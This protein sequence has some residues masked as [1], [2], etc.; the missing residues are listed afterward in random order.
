MN[1]LTVVLLLPLFGFLVAMAL[2][3][4]SPESSRVWA[5]AGSL[6]TFAASL[7]LLF[8][9]DRGGSGEQFTV[10]VP[11]ITTPDIHFSVAVN[12]VSLWLILLST[13]LTP[14]C[15]LISWNSVARRVKEFYA[16]LILLEFALMGV[17]MAQDL[18]L[19][20]VFWEVSLV[21]MYFLIGIWGHDRRIYATVKFFLYTMA[22]SMLMLTAIIYIYIHTQTFNYSAI[23]ERLSSGKLVFAPGEQ[24]LLFLAFFIA[25]AI[26]VPLFP[27]HTWLPDAHVEAPTAGSVMLASVM[28]K[29]GTYGLLHYCLPLF[30]AAARTCAPWIAVLAII[31]IV[32]GALVAMVQPNLKKLVAYSS[33]SHLGFVVLGIFSFTQA[34]MDGAVYVMLA[35][36]VSTGALFAIV[37]LLYERR[38]SLE[39]ADYGGVAT[40]AP[41]LSTVFLVT[42]LAS[43]GLPMLSNFVGEFLVLQGAAI[44]D[45]KW[46]VYASLGVILSACYMLWMYQRVIYGEVN[47]EVR[48]HMADLNLREWAAV[49]PLLAMMVWMGVYSQSF[50]PPVSQV[51]AHVLE[52]TQV[53]VPYRVDKDGG[54][55]PVASGLKPVASG[56]WP[57]A[58]ELAAP[59]V[60]WDHGSATPLAVRLTSHR[61]PFHRPPA[62]GHRPPLSGHRPPFPE[63]ANAR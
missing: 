25:F 49:A 41:W 60:W 36:G 6:V 39:I 59:L 53:N 52:Q 42:T 55:W 28:L 43:I 1:L 10:D 7:G 9:F 16:F 48:S 46:A 34:G 22:G 4:T 3:R 31:G 13:F 40:V 57:V 58:G 50:L 32:Y 20:F 54:R 21:P 8:W 2:P 33:V 29:M 47:P 37:G 18:F 12:G 61:P 56:R 15:V 51:T 24:M 19:F 17:F 62:T 23:L 35:H 45:F 30:P 14:V 27:L 63:V 26:K 44:A 5:L 11:W 38:H